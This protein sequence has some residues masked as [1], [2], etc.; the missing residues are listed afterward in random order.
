MPAVAI[1]VDI[2]LPIAVGSSNEMGAEQLEQRDLEPIIQHM[3]SGAAWSM[4]PGRVLFDL[5][6]GVARC[7]GRINVIER[8]M[9]RQLDPMV[10]TYGVNDWERLY[11]LAPG[12]MDIGAR[13]AAII[14]AIRAR[15][16]QSIPYW[17]ALLE[18]FGYTNVVV[19]PL[20]N[21]FRC[22]DRIRKRLQSN[23]WAF[24][25]RIS[26]DSIPEL[27]DAMMARVRRG[28]RATVYIDFVLT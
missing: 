15:G 18:S 26:A 17:T 20:E 19:T 10:A 8:L 25:F 22:G 24:A 7:F 21:R 16:G 13:R 14:A 28:V 5:L 4:V 27:D 1:Q 23:Y 9:V 12:G 2:E 6:A 11:A 3:P